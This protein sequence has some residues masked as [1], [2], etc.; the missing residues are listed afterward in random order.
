MASESASGRASY[1]VFAES[2]CPLQLRFTLI[3]LVRPVL[4]AFPILVQPEVGPQINPAH[5]LVGGERIRS[6][7]S[8]NNA[9][10]H[11]VCPVRDPQRL[12]HVVIRNQHAD[13]TLLQVKN[14]LL[15]VGHR[16]W[17]DPRE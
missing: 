5:I 9:V 13:A 7:T 14:D 2:P 17:I 3:R 12:A 6:A 16:D 1:A 10:V 15:N 11:D 8:K 4:G